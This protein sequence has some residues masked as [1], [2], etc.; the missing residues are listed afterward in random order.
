MTVIK[1]TVVLPVVAAA[2]SLDRD[3]VNHTWWF[4]TV[5]AADQTVAN[6]I[7]GQLFRFYGVAVTEGPFTG[8]VAASFSSALDGE[9]VLVKM[10]DMGDP[11]PRVPFFVEESFDLPIP[12]TGGNLPHEIAL[13]LSFEGQAASGIAMARRRGRVY[14]GPFN[15]GQDVA[16]SG[17]DS[18]PEPE[19]MQVIRAAA[20]RLADDEFE[21]GEIVGWR[22][23][24]ET[25]G[26]VIP[27]RK[28]WVD[29]AWDTQRRRGFAATVRMERTVPT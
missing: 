9:N 22:Q 20:A 16:V 12:T 3:S 7:S 14:L 23:R 27:V 24:S 8:I 26:A 21:A 10:Y 13:C 29:N 11:E 1:A 4:E 25:T 28:V 17:Q 2:G 6:N 18:R 15:S 5:G 19:L